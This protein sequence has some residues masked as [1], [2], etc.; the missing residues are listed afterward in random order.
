[1]DT[2]PPF[3][4][5]VGRRSSHP[6]YKVT[7]QIG[8][9]PISTCKK[10]CVSSEVTAALESSVAICSP[11]ARSVTPLASFR[12]SGRELRPSVARGICPASPSKKVARSVR[13]SALYYGRDVTRRFPGMADRPLDAVIRHIRKVAG[14]P[15]NSREGDQELLARFID[16]Q[17]GTAFATLVQRH[18]PMVRRVCWRLLRHE[19][20][21]D[22][23][24]QAT[25]LVLLHKA[26]AIRRR[27]SLASWLYGVAFRTALKARS[28]AA[29]RQAH[30]PRSIGTPPAEPWR[31]VAW[32]EM[33]TVLDEEMRGLS[34][35][36]RAAAGAVLSGGPNATR[37]LTSWVG[38]CDAPTPAGAGTGNPPHPADS[39]WINTFCGIACHG[40]VRTC[41]SCCL[42]GR[43]RELYG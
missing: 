21:V 35:R 13:L 23:A 19:S 2:E 3:L 30:E 12:L 41:G 6:C 10:I 29:Q 26:C 15:L 36:Y 37:R 11:P 20:D 9:E 33:C 16:H 7:P 31:E 4:G 38:L 1:M 39:P 24:F 17:D 22:D 28:R 27:R 18:G 5:H 34:E 25:F 40:P 43:A 42:T 8:P 32:R 14:G